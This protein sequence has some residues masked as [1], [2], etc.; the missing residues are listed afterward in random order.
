[1]P[2]IW[3]GKNVGEKLKGAEG[4]LRT[5]SEGKYGE[6]EDQGDNAESRCRSMSAFG[7]RAPLLF[8]F[9][10]P[11]S[12]T[13]TTQCLLIHQ[14]HPQRG[15]IFTHPNPSPKGRG[16]IKPRYG[17]SLSPTSQEL[18]SRNYNWVD[19]TLEQGSACCIPCWLVTHCMQAAGYSWRSSYPPKSGARLLWVTKS[20]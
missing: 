2:R 9:S 10:P 19:F 13:P 11:I 1:M 12:N 16:R 17:L 4:G 8:T 6:F 18:C 20:L 14:T 5:H 15:D 7:R 3:P